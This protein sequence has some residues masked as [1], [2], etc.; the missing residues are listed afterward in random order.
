MIRL[1]VSIALMLVVGLGYGQYSSP[2]QGNELPKIIPP[3]PTVASLMHFEEVPVDYYSGQPDIQLPIYSKNV[4]SGLTIPISLRYNTMGLR[5]DERS[6]WVGTGWALDGE[7]V[8]SRTVRHIRDEAQLEEAPFAPYEVGI[9]HNGFFE[10]DFDSYNNEDEELQRFLWNA[11]GRGSGSHH[12]HGDYDK[13]PDLYQLSLFGKNARFVIIKNA[14]RALEVKMLSNDSNLKVIPN[15]DANTYHIASFTVTDTHGISYFMSVTEVSTSDSSSISWLQGG[16]GDST[17]ESDHR[18]KNHVSAWKVKEIR[19]STNQLLA[20]YNYQMVTEAFEAP[21]SFVKA[22]LSARNSSTVMREFLGINNSDATDAQFHNYNSSVIKPRVTASQTA[23]SVASQKVSAIVFKDGSKVQF[24][25]GTYNHPEYKDSGRVLEDIKI[26]DTNN[27][28][29]K[30]FDL[31][32]ETTPNKLLFLDKLTEYFKQDSNSFTYD[33]SYR[34][35]ELLPF[36]TTRGDESYK[37]K[38]LWGYYK[39]YK[40]NQISIYTAEKSADKDFVSTGSLTA[41]SY[42]TGGKKEFMFES[43]EFSSMGFRNFTENEFKN[44]NPS[45]WSWSQ[46]P[47]VFFDAHGS[48]R[49]L[50]DQEYFTI[51]DEQEVLLTFHLLHGDANDPSLQSVNIH[52]DKVEQRPGSEE[53]ILERMAGGMLEPGRDQKVV[54][55]PGQYKLHYTNM[56]S[57]GINTDIRASARVTYKTFKE[58]FDHTMHGGGLRIKSVTFRDIDNSIKRQYKYVYTQEEVDTRGMPGQTGYT[59]TGS[60]DGFLTNIREYEEHIP[61]ALLQ[62]L[63][64]QSTE[65]IELYPWVATSNPSTGNTMVVAPYKV[66]PIFDV[67]EYINSV[68]VSMTKNN[69]VGYRKVSVT[70]QNNGRTVYEYTSPTDF[71]TYHEGYYRN[72]PF[73]PLKDKSH[74]HGALIKQKVYDNDDR[75][76]KEVTNTY[77]DPIEI[78]QAFWV[79]TDYGKACSWLQFYNIYDSYITRSSNQGN[80]PS[81]FPESES[82]GNCNSDLRPKSASV[83]YRKYYHYYYRYLLGETHTK[84]YFYKESPIPSIV[85]TRQTYTYD[86]SN[87][88]ISTHNTYLTE[89]ANEEHYQTKYYYPGSSFAGNY[90]NYST[91]VNQNKIED[92]VVTEKFKDAVMLS[93]TYTTYSNFE[94]NTALPEYIYTSKGDVRNTSEPGVPGPAILKDRFE[95]RITYYNYDGSGNPLE[96]SKESGAIISYIWGYDDQFPI[97]KIENADY[98]KIRQ[99][100]GLGTTQEVENL[101]ESH[102]TLINSL[103]DL[104]LLSDSMVTTYTYDPLIGVTSMTDPKGYT[105]HYSY[106]G[107]NRLKEVRDQDNKLINDY[108]Y[109]YQGQ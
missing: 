3:S 68:N 53:I 74:L 2:Q 50:N 84:D 92:I 60:I 107:F 54:L 16:N 1:C 109:H 25:L 12:L 96:L 98:Q 31:V 101:D 102:M 59:S 89:G 62:W 100:L 77:Q 40:P 7:A 81:I 51:T 41:I 13:E 105:I 75:L 45:N 10:Q 52:L 82:L 5:I 91:L 63:G 46:D 36:P 70:E 32:Y 21:D 95:K 14:S 71:P 86:S 6:G 22:R 9:Y 33:L 108:K 87:Y 42:P 28:I 30:R 57:P 18:P 4:G 93:S 66:T 85:E 34:D 44:L 99:A 67:K 76:L 23:I 49:E 8:I 83:F 65:G 24:I 35:K 48:D 47:E 94:D 39:K 88:K 64:F 26:F 11:A 104:P 15:Y 56:N 90:S 72:K 103:R 106:D 20:T 19:N 43:N 69:Y 17:S 78:S 29:F 97:A 61:Y 55:S 79:F 27:H 37:Y 73:L 58:N 38:D 80:M